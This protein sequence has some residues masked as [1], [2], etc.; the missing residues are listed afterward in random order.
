[1]NKEDI[2]EYLN[3]H[4]YSITSKHHPE[5]SKEI[6]LEHLELR[7]KDEVFKEHYREFIN[8]HFQ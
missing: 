3:K 2:F 6:V 8:L 1:M 5:F 4:G 7:D